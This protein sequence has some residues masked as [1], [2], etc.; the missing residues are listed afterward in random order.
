MTFVLPSLRPTLTEPPSPGVIGARLFSPPP[1]SRRI[2]W[3]VDAGRDF[4]SAIR[5]QLLAL[6]TWLT[7]RETPERLTTRG[8]N[9]YGPGDHREFK[10]LTP[11]K[12]LQA[13]D[14]ISSGLLVAKTVHLICSPA[15]AQMVCYEL[16]GGLDDRFPSSRTR[17]IWEPVPDLC[18]P[19]HRVEMYKTLKL[20]HVISPNHAELAG[21]YG[22]EDPIDI[23]TPDT[24]VSLATKLVTAGIG[25]NGTGA[26]IVR[27]GKMGCLVSSRK[28]MNVWLPA[29]YQPEGEERQGNSDEDNDTNNGNK[30]KSSSPNAKDGDKS[31]PKVV[32]PTGG[33][34]A[35]IGGLAIGLVRSGG[36]FVLAAAMGTV[37]ASFAIEQIGIPTL[38]KKDGQELWNGVEVQGRLEEYRK[39][40]EGMGIG[41]G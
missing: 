20:M 15:R 26:V 17:F 36:N 11:K 9:S 35:F 5:K 24:I 2:G 19:E 16:R 37:A 40:V 27:C 12:R 21:F 8:W 10:Y 25:P 29:Y 23:N 3:I 32:D 1:D 41:L 22:I 14:L 6:D 18:T 28:R 4:P 31:H 33:G 34:N 13:D 30:N 38:S 39:K 7:I